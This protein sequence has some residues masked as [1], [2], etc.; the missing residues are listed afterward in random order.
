[1][2]GSLLLVAAGCG[3]GAGPERD[4]PRIVPWSA[5]GDAQIGSTRTEVHRAYGRPLSHGSLREHWPPGTRYAGR[6][7]SDEAYRVRGG[8]LY[9]RYVDDVV[10]MVGTTSP[11][12][13]T[14][15]GL[16]IGTRISRG[17]CRGQKGSCNYTWHGF[18][19]DDCTN[20]W[21]RAGHAV[22]VEV[23]MNRSLYGYAD[24]RV[25]WVGFGDPN[26]VLH[27]F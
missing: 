4:P 25:T 26:V 20:Q 16:H 5:I 10:K 1:M 7:V 3:D 17:P 27:C 8:K 22:D 12:Y 11:R 6:N 18:A 14:P 2:V 21:Y 19:F 9:V 24:G 13:V 15:D 23:G